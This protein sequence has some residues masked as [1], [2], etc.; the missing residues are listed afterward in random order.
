MMNLSA[1]IVLFCTVAISSPYTVSAE[2]ID[3]LCCL[4][5]EC[6][7]PA[8]GRDNLN[9]DQFGTTCYEQLLSMADTENSSTNGSGE[10][11]KQIAL[12]RNRCCNSAYTPIDI[13]I[14]PT[15]APVINLPFGSEPFCNLCTDGR[16]PGKPKTV[17]AVLYIPGNPKCELLY[18]MGQRG[19]IE[20]RLCNPM[21][22]YLEEACGCADAVTA[23]APVAPVPAPNVVTAT[24]VA[25]SNA[26]ADEKVDLFERKDLP[27]NAGVKNAAYKLSEGRVRG[28][29]ESRRRL[30]KGA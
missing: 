25:A 24:S 19:L 6:Y 18:Y 1:W 2:G 9:V 7:F 8:S 21:Q 20:D 16:F 3:E 11:T 10:C 4:C 14:A 29:G 27:D 15:P 17:T 22:D 23:Q 30:L 26:A 5:D 13:A 12:H 28:S